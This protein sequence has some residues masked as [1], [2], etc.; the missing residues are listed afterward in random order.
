VPKAVRVNGYDAE[1]LGAR[2]IEWLLSTPTGVAPACR[3]LDFLRGNMRRGGRHV[4]RTVVCRTLLTDR[5]R[6][7]GEMATVEDSEGAR[8]TPAEILKLRSILP[9]RFWVTEMSLPDLY[10]ANKH[11]IGDVIIDAAASKERHKSRGGDSLAFAWLPG[12]AR[13][14][15]GLA[16]II[17]S[18]S[19]KGHI[20][21]LRH[22]DG[23]L[24]TLEW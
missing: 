20:P 7:C 4:H 12:L 19:L 16:N 24:P 14:G 10:T 9:A 13:C 22:V 15:P 1:S 5:N 11:K 17:P 2:V 6:Y 18:W 21:L 8:L 23:P 3:W